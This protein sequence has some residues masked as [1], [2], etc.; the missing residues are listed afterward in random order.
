MQ[1]FKISNKRRTKFRL[2]TMLM[3]AFLNLLCF[4]YLTKFFSNFDLISTLLFLMVNFILIV[5]IVRIECFEYDSSGEVISIRS[6]HPLFRNTEKRTEFPKDR[7][8]D[9]WISQNYL[10]TIYLKLGVE[11]YNSKKIVVSHKLYC[12]SKENRRKIQTS[13]LQ[14]KQLNLQS[15]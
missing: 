2:N 7:L 5:Q 9:F 11:N 3:L 14:L 13:F 8:Y 6:M 4:M 15:K 10:G 1:R 12:C